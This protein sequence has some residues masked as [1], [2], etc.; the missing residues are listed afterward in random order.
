VA[1][2]RSLGIET[3]AEGIETHEQ[4]ARMAALGCAFGQGYA[5]AHP[6]TAVDLLSDFGSASVTT[7][8]G[9][10]DATTSGRREADGRAATASRRPASP[11][12][13]AAPGRA[14]RRVS[15]LRP[16]AS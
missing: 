2:G 6:M 9:V 11:K 4:A 10:K 3:I 12:P 13:E 14:P 8:T 1:I 7:A 5:F 16:S 15:A